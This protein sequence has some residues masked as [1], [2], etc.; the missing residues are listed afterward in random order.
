M[1]YFGTLRSDFFIPKVTVYIINSIKY[2][3]TASNIPSSHNHHHPL[4]VQEQAQQG[5]HHVFSTEKPTNNV[6]S[7]L[8][9]IWWETTEDPEYI[10]HCNIFSFGIT[11]ILSAIRHVQ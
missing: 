8:R 4:V 1:T 9:E 6:Y 3:L 5:Q 11:T 2:C 10:Y 7:T